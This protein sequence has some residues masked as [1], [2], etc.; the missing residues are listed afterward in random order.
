M[1]RYRVCFDGKWQ[2]DFDDEADALGWAREVADTGRLV[3]VARSRF[4]LPRLI[5]VLPE[6]RAE[7]GEWLWKTRDRG[8]VP[9]TGAM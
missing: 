1:A 9:T 5:A 4:S 2:G 7:E 8:W 3:Y 6:D